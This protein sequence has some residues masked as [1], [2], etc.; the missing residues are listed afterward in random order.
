MKLSLP[1]LAALCGLGLAPLTSSAA[2][3]ASS[4]PAPSTIAPATAAGT[5]TFTEAGRGGSSSTK[6]TLKL[7][8][9]DGKLTGVLI[10]GET[11]A[12][13]D[14]NAQAASAR[15]L[16]ALPEVHIADAS[17]ENGIIA[18]SVSREVNGQTRTTKYSGKLTGNKIIGSAETPGRNGAPVARAWSASRAK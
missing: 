15:P 6:H 11:V 12:A 1:L 4:T 9:N 8:V 2:S 14:A 18:F 10:P 17:F 13:P 16:P 7:S 5:W 3:A